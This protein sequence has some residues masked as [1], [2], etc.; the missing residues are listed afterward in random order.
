MDT[1]VA[2]RT[3]CNCCGDAG[4]KFPTFKEET[5]G[6]DSRETFGKWSLITG[7][8]VRGS[9]LRALLSARP[10]GVARPFG[11]PPAPLGRLHCPVGC[12]TRVAACRGFV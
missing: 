11:W 1:R 6:A 8:Q 4:Q 7:V 5:E 2:M 12:L 10:A 9:V 3:R